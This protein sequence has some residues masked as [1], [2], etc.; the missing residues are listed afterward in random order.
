MALSLAH[1]PKIERRA[2]LAALITAVVLTAV[3]FVAYFLTGSAAVFSDALESIVNVVAAS[4]A[5]Y[6]LY[7]THIPADPDH[8]Y[9]HGKIEFLSA[10][11][12]GGMILLAALLAAAKAFDNFVRTGQLRIAHL[13]LGIVLLCVA[14]ISN[15][16][17]G[18]IL[19]RTGRRTR[20]ATLE[21]DGQH[22]MSDAVTSAAALAGLVAVRLTGLAWADSAAALLVAL[23]ISWIGARLVHE[24]IGG[25][26]DRQDNSD[27]RLLRGILDSHV[28]PR[29][30]SPRICSYHKLRHRH[31]GRYHWVDF[32]IMVPGGWNVRHSHEVASAIEYEIEL[33]LKEGNA[34]AHIEPCSTADCPSCAIEKMTAVNSTP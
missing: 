11:L 24:A 19:V 23:Y 34:T 1:I 29:G 14:L 3:K 30:K 25:L 22:L 21:A 32:H 20:S 2:A 28:G 16:V 5:L 6:S 12:E 15:A 26:M 18:L 10:G 7:W 8:P 9:G 27:Q 17:V 13:R 4:F 31:S 33:A